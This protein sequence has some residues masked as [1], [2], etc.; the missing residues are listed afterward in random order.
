[1]NIGTN[2]ITVNTDT[3]SIR[4]GGLAVYDSGSTGL[5]GSLLWDSQNNHWVYSNPSGSSYSGG[6][7]ISGPRTSTLGSETG[8]T[9]CM[10]LAGQGGDHLTSSMIYHSSTVTCI[11]NAIVG[12]S[13]ACFQSTGIFGSTLTAGDVITTTANSGGTAICLKGRSG[14]NNA[15]TIR[16]YTNDGAT[17]LGRIEI[18]DSYTEINNIS[19]GYMY[20]STN[21]T[22]RVR[23]TSTGI[24]CFACTVCSPYF[25]GTNGVVS[26]ANIVANGGTIT[27]TTST[28]GN[29][30]VFIANAPDNTSDIGFR[31]QTGGTLKWFIGMPNNI[32]N[33]NFSIFDGNCSADRLTIDTS[34]NI[35]IGIN[36]IDK[37]HV[38]GNIISEGCFF[39]G[40]PD[41][42]RIFA[43]H[44]ATV[45]GNANC[46]LV[47][48]AGG[49]SALFGTPS[50]WGG[51]AVVYTCG[52]HRLNIGTTGI[53]CFSCQICA[54]SA[55]FGGSVVSRELTV[56][57]GASDSIGAGAYVFYSNTDSTRGAVHQLNAAFGLDT[58]TFN[59]SNWSRRIT[60]SNEGISC[61]AGTVCAPRFS[62]TFYG[63]HYGF[64][65]ISNTSCLLSSA[66][67]DVTIYFT[68]GF[69]IYY[70]VNDYTVAA[71]QDDNAAIFSS[72]RALIPYNYYQSTSTTTN[73]ASYVDGPNSHSALAVAICKIVNSNTYCIAV[74][75]A[76]SSGNVT[77]VRIALTTNGIQPG[78]S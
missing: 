60:L 17:Q 66:S 27:S 1:L 37:L 69:N 14:S 40:A 9:S 19:N 26:C 4:F 78:D 48:Q 5:T 55:N 44:W 52:Q 3:P 61:F 6:M 75:F 23:I 51:S 8:T 45:S 32:V 64:S 77:G 46:Y 35:G 38:N 43:G 62:G 16:Y 59:G 63:T 34:G 74:R 36:P 42:L 67:S 65:K 71:Y 22:E 13:T 33:N 58:Y 73:L 20:F 70:G 57:K 49:G 68:S 76:K 18:N 11:P 21:N 15:S 53:A 31:V 41:T 47:F 54:P 7:F 39:S 29:G 50:G 25:V 2:L 30:A 10:L 72:L 24:A 28:I 12:G 56:N